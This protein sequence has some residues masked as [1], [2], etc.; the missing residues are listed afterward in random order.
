MVNFF[1]EKQRGLPIETKL[2]FFYWKVE[3]VQNERRRKGEK[4]EKV[5]QKTQVSILNKGFEYN[6]QSGDVKL[7]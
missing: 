4:Y 7:F 3:F 1:G 5:C 2:P 6:F